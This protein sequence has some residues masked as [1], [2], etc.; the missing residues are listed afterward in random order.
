LPEVIAF[1][2]VLFLYELSLDFMLLEAVYTSKIE[3]LCLQWL[4]LN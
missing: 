2:V 1:A 4:V 3:T